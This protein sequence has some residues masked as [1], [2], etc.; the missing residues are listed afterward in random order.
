MNPESIVNIEVQTYSHHFIKKTKKIHGSQAL[1]K[2]A[3]HVPFFPS[4]F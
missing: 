2:K 3:I 4:A 1:G